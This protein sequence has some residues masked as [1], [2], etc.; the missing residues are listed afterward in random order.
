VVD[1]QPFAI[2]TT[3]GRVDRTLYIHGSSASRMLRSLPGGVALCFTATILD[4]LVFSRSAFHNSMNYRSVMVLGTAVKVEGGE[5]LRGLEA[6]TEHMARGRW[7]DSRPPTAQEL[8]ATSV[9][10]IDIAE[11]SAK[12]RTGGPKEE[13]ADYALPIWGG[14]LPLTL[15]PGA[16]V[17]DGRL[18]NGVE[19]PDYVRE[20]RR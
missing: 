3:F 15:Q 14:H 9:L 20:Y 2:P 12:V 5:K 19:V 11:A 10:R 17:D 16:A 8:K 18:L 1:G 4:G 6:V 13:E 7:A